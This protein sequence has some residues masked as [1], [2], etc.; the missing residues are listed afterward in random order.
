MGRTATMCAIGGGNT[1]KKS[2]LGG[3]NEQLRG[4]WTGWTW[5]GGKGHSLR[6]RKVAATDLED[7]PRLGQGMGKGY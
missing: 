1:Y 7:G 2:M 4:G 6:S 5:T 3:V